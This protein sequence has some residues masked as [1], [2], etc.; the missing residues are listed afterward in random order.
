MCLM[1][2]DPRTTRRN[3]KNVV[4]EIFMSKKVYSNALYC[5]L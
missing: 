4:L 3:E 5:V 2:Q 1:E